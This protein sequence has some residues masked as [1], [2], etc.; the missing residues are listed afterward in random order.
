MIFH[1]I[2]LFKS[3]FIMKLK[4]FILLFVGV[5]F[6]SCSNDDVTNDLQDQIDQL[7]TTIEGLQSTITTLRSDLQTATTATGA[8]SGDLATAQQALSD[9]QA[10]L[11]IARGLVDTAGTD[12]D[13][14]EASLAFVRNALAGI[15]YSATVSLDAVGTVS[16]QSAAQARQTIYGKWDI[17]GASAKHFTTKRGACSFDFIEFMEDSYIL[18]IN[19]PEDGETGRLFGTYILNEDAD[20]DVTSVDLMFDLGATDMRVARLTN[21]VVS[22][23]ADVLNASFDVELTLPEALEVCEASLPGSVTAP[24]EEPVEEAESATAVSNHAKL[25]GQWS[26]VSLDASDGETLET[27][28]ADFC[29][30]YND[31]TGEEEPI[32][33]CTAP[34]G[35]IINFSNFGT[36]SLTMLSADGS[37]LGVQIEDWTWDN[38]QTVLVLEMDGESDR[39]DLV[40]ISE[41]RLVFRG[42]Y[43][44][45][46][47]NETTGEETE[48]TITETITCIRL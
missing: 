20:G 17:G 27:V 23:S 29:I 46:Q 14:L 42:T 7:E 25:I 47:Y 2:I 18:S 13:D 38:D 10:A 43:T 4:Q 12:I 30:D 21:I 31:E 11:D 40:E 28:L 36:Y 22:E 3:I 48:V 15:D 26:V 1:N 39:Y 45:M 5:I 33:N 9:A 16:S 6:I 35:A 34:A 41:T 37:P 32:A 19:L 44:D 8:L 24:K